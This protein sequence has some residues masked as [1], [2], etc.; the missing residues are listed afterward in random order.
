MLKPSPSVY[1]SSIPSRFTFLF[2]NLSRYEPEKGV[3]KLFS[4]SFSALPLA[5][6]VGDKYMI[7][8]GGLFSDDKV[9]LDGIGALG[10]LSIDGEG[11]LLPFPRLL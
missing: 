3:F 1:V 6:L 10:D 9:T 5:T 7:L 11:P 2:A 4:E 8:H